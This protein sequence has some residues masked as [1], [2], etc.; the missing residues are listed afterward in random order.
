MSAAPTVLDGSKLPGAAA[1]M[2][3]KRL[4][5]VRRTS[6]TRATRRGCVLSELES[7]AAADA[8]RGADEQDQAVVQVHRGG[9]RDRGVAL[10]AQ[11][12][13]VGGCPMG[14]LASELAESD[15]TAR[16]ALADG[17]GTWQAR[18]TAGLRTMRERGELAADSDVDA[19]APGLVAAAQGGL[20]LTQTARSTT[21]LESA[22][23]LALDGIR[24]RRTAPSRRPRAA[25]GAEG[26]RSG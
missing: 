10:D 15:P 3:M 19:L 2:L 17:F 4:M 16:A 14:R 12:A 21:P 25:R 6:R 5:H 8:G 26:G 18:L 13:S 7:Q 1:D 24:A 11:V 23:D 9:W 20:L 22:L